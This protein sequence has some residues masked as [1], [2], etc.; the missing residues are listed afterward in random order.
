[1]QRRSSSGLAHQN[2][3]WATNEAN[4]KRHG[5][6]ALV[7]GPKPEVGSSFQSDTKEQY[8]LLALRTVALYFDVLAGGNLIVCIQFV[9]SR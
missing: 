4:G 1:M 9:F 3:P 6:V 8:T 2:E 5:K 7:L